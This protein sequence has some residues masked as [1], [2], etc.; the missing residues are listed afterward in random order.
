MT[1]LDHST[2]LEERYGRN[3]PLASSKLA[4]LALRR[5]IAGTL[6]PHEKPAKS[7]AGALNEVPRGSGMSDGK[8]IDSGN[9]VDEDDVYLYPTGM[10]AIWHAH[11]LAMAW[12]ER[13]D[14]APGK[15]VCFG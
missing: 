2:F 8:V 9:K 5:R 13:K 10:S 15:S 4:K 3:L 12:K 1:S 11:Q 7:G 6:L 14:G